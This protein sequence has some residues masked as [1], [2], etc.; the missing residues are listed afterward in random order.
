MLNKKI[1]VTSILSTF[2]ISACSS[3]HTPEFDK[4]HSKNEQD[5]Q[6]TY[7]KYIKQMTKT[8]DEIG[9]VITDKPYVN[10]DNLYLEKDVFAT[11]GQLV[12]KAIRIVHD[13]GAKTLT[14]NEVR[15]KLK[16]KKRT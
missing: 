14:P 9:E 10:K 3:T 8:Q 7:A 6:E 2:L 5:V 11:N 13:L 12:E 1:L 15:D 16:L 4:K